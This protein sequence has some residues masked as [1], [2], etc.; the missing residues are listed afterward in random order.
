VGVLE[1]VV[2]R[3]RVLRLATGD[4]LTMFTDGVTEARREGALYGDERLRACV[5]RT[6]PS[7]SGIVDA[8]LEDVVAFQRGDLRDDVALVSLRVLDD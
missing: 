1:T 7:A 5:E 6:E 8:I 2:F 3:D 4:V